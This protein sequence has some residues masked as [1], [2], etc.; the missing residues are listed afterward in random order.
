MVV[1]RGTTY[2]EML[3]ADIDKLKVYPVCTFNCYT[4]VRS[5]LAFRQVHHACVINGISTAQSENM[6][7]QSCHGYIAP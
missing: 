6:P 4:V 3:R 1:I 2:I 5:L 7:W